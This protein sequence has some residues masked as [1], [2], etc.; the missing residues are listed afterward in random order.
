MVAEYLG[1]LNYDQAFLELKTAYE[2]KKVEEIKNACIQLMNAHFTTRERLPI[3]EDFYK[4]IF[5]TTGEVNSILDLACGIN[6]LAVLWMPQVKHYY[7]YDINIPRVNFINKL[8][9]LNNLPEDAQAKDVLVNIPSEQGDVALLLKEI[10]RM[11]ER[12]KALTIKLLEEVQVKWLVVSIPVSNMRK[13]WEMP[14]KYEASILAVIKEHNWPY[15]VLEFDTEKVFLIN[16][17]VY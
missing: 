11:F 8:L 12:N 6:P 16:K 1:D 14:K 10:H 5:E 7:A 2:T 4:K 17:E 9:N 13:E 15:F 3:L